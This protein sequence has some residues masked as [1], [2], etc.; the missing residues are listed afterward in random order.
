MVFEELK[1]KYILWASHKTAEYGTYVFW[2]KNACGYTNCL[3]KC[4]IYDTFEQAQKDAER[5][6]YLDVV[7]IKIEQLLPY[8]ETRTYLNDNVELSLQSN[9]HKWKDLYKDSY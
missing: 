4:H 5:N 8:M 7:P 9:K 6:V 2:K 1:D 3:E